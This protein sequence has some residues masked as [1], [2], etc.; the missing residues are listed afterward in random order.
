MNI[1]YVEKLKDFL[2]ENDIDTEIEL[3]DNQEYS[4]VVDDNFELGLLFFKLFSRFEND[5]SDFEDQD[6]R[7]LIESFQS[8]KLEIADVRL[9]Y[10]KN[11]P[12]SFL[13][14]LAK[15]KMKCLINLD[16]DRVLGFVNL[17]KEVY[18][19]D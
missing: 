1:K 14:F 12:D 15:R 7:C 6:V 8:V 3:E 10:D 13:S 16:Y 9:N 19:L 5:F 11:S 18:D 2:S 17:F 4:K